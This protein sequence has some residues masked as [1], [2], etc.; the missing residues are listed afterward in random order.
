VT[1]H[2]T[3]RPPRAN[4]RW[5]LM[6]LGLTALQAAVIFTLSDRSPAQAV[7]HRTVPKVRVVTGDL[8]GMV[9]DPRLLALPTAQGF[10]GIGWR[11]AV[12][13]QYIAQ[14]W[15][16]PIPWLSQSETGLARTLLAAPAV[17]IGRGVTA[18]KPSPQFATNAL[19]ALPLAQATIVRLASSN[20][21]WEWVEPLVAPAI[22]HSNVLSETEVEVTVDRSGQVFSVFVL[23]SSGL[24]SADQLAQTLARSARFR[25]TRSNGEPEEWCRGRL[26]FE[27][28]TLAPGSTAEEAATRGS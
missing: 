19:P 10:A 3:R 9:A 13:P 1:T 24:R 5:I 8:S 25:I 15:T 14:D 4:L 18:D 22:T 6:A 16:E 2:L 27:W 11:I 12:N 23:R 26:I 20:A 28:H 21:T 7:P 17:G